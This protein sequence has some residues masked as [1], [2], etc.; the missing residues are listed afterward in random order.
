MQKEQ[1][2]IEKKL[3][4]EVAAE[5]A[6]RLTMPKGPTQK[7]LLQAMAIVAFDP[8]IKVTYPIQLVLKRAI[9]VR[10][11]FGDWSKK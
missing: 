4:A 3:A 2:E 1:E 7:L 8:A 6:K 5:V 10:K 9:K 11:S